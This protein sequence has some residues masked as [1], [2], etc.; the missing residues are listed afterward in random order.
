M[1]S[2]FQGKF[3]KESD[4]D[5][6]EHYAKLKKTIKKQRSDEASVKRIITH[7]E[8]EKIPKKHGLEN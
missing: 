5:E 3:R 4:Y 6:D 7:I 8:S 1:V 2:K